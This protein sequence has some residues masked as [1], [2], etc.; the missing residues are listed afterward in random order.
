MAEDDESSA[1]S[2]SESDE[3]EGETLKRVAVTQSVDGKTKTGKEDTVSTSEEGSEDEEGSSSS[4]ES[5]SAS[6]MDVDEAVEVV[7][8]VIS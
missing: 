6:E 7:K 4:E 1:T 5:G 8:D 2:D 3:D